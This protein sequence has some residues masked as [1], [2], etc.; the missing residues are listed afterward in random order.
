M[1]YFNKNKTL[2]WVLGALLIINLAATGTLIYNMRTEPQ[3][4]LRVK[5]KPC[6][7]DYLQDELGLSTGQVQEFALLK[8]AHHDSLQLI[9]TIMAEKRLLISQTMVMPEPDTALLDKTTE[10]LGALYAQTRRMFVSHYFELRK[11]C[12]PQQQEKLAKIFSGAFCSG[13]KCG[14]EPESRTGHEGCKNHKRT[15]K[16]RCKV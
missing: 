9:R 12:D 6:V 2:L 14:I 5:D 15:N 4:H 13:D 8:K 16:H 11:I 7:Q 3:R 1:S 10:E